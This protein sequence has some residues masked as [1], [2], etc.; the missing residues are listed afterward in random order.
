MA[1][2]LVSSIF[3]IRT[4]LLDQIEDYINDLES[5][6]QSVAPGME[7]L[8]QVLAYTNLSFAQALS[9]GPVDPKMQNRK[10]AWKLPVRR[11]TGRY[12]KGWKV[13][14]VAR[15]AYLV[16]NLS[17]EA[18]FIEH[19]IHPTGSSRQ[20]KIRGPGGY[21]G[22]TNF[23][24][25]V[26]RPVGKMSVIKT[27]RFADQSRVSHRVLEVVLEPMRPGRTYTRRG[28]GIAIS[29]MTTRLNFNKTWRGMV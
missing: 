8:T 21:R 2:P 12:Y 24:M 29:N 11:I 25:R 28:Q 1:R 4:S 15:G 26:R 22:G 18:Y 27:L 3:H 10:A 5:T 6:K 16:Y 7:I 20:T 13:R 14:R 23:I 19:G 17:R 9:R